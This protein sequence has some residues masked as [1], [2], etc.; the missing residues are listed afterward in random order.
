MTWPSLTSPDGV[1]TAERSVDVTFVGPYL[2]TGNSILT[3]SKT[4]AAI[5]KAGEINRANLKLAALGNSTSEAEQNTGA[6]FLDTERD[7]DS[8]SIGIQGIGG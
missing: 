8:D 6:G 5:K 1:I 7:F 2:L 4:L 3:N